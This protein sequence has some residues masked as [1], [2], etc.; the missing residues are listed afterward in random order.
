MGK[1]GKVTFDQVEKVSASDMGNG[2]WRLGKSEIC[3]G[4]NSPGACYVSLSMAGFTRQFFEV[5]FLDSN[6]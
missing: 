5:E 6:W 2:L 4:Q 3:V 1:V